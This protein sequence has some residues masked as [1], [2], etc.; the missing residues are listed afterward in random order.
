MQWLDMIS[1]AITK[2]KASAAKEKALRLS[3]TSP[4]QAPSL[5]WGSVSEDFSR[6]S[7]IQKEIQRPGKV[8]LRTRADRV[9]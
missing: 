5:G 2:I 8:Q 1:R 3:G 9:W 6:E 7:D 4:A